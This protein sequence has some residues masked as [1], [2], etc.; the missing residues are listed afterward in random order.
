M[1]T[2]RSTDAPPP[3]PISAVVITR[4]AARH[5]AAVLAAV[6]FCA[7]ILVLDSGS[8]DDTVAIARAAGARVEHQPFL[9]YG[10]QKQRAV[11]LACHDWI[12]SLDADEVLDDEARAAVR[13]LPLHDP[14]ACYALHRTTYVG[15]RPVR[16]GPWRDDRVL[17]LFHRSTA[18]FKPLP[19]HEAVEAQRPPILLPGTIRH[20]SYDSCADV[21]ARS[22]RYA[23]LKAA[24]MRDKRQR[25]GGVSMPLRGLTAFVKNYVLRGGWRDGAVGFVVAL[26]RVIDST[27]PRA[28]LLEGERPTG[29]GGPQV[30]TDRSAASIRS[31]SAGSGAENVSRSPDAG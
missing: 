28:M 23:P 29:P 21:L 25:V 24:I 4:D 17:R 5:L 22:L 13:S 14:A 9:G 19:V 10:P 1:T 7:E 15:D 16:H 27:L 18:A 6:D 2:A 11:D 20:F 31:R 26:A 8:T 30:P 3:R 12:L